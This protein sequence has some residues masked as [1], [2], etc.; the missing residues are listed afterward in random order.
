MLLQRSEIVDKLMS[1]TF[2]KY[3]DTLESHFLS[4]LLM[5]SKIYV[6]WRTVS[7]NGVIVVIKVFLGEIS[8]NHLSRTHIL[9]TSRTDLITFL[10]NLDALRSKLTRH[11]RLIYPAIFKL[12][13][14]LSF[15]IIL[16]LIRVPIVIVVLVVGFVL[17]IVIIILYL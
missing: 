15:I 14:S 2:I 13:H 6:S 11:G 10:M 8:N 9:H 4:R 5:S 1:L 16:R 3:I 7:K 12:H 17:D